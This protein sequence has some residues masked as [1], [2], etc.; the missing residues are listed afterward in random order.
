MQ[1]TG[2]ITQKWIL[3][4]NLTFSL[5]INWGVEKNELTLG[6]EWAPFLAWNTAFDFL[7]ILPPKVEILQ[8]EVSTYFCLFLQQNAENRQE[9][10]KV[11]CY[12]LQYFIFLRMNFQ[13]LK[14]SHSRSDGSSFQ[15]Q[16]ERTGT[17]N[18]IFVKLRSL[19]NV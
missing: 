19:I 3:H 11:A 5:C 9:Y 10:A 8:F 16:L 18:N 7:K 14:R 12:K 6:S 15:A 4:L 17:V 13:K 2:I 1:T